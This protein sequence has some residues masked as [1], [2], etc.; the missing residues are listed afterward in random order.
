VCTRAPRSTVGG[1]GAVVA[2]SGRAGFCVESPSKF[3][4]LNPAGCTGAASNC[5]AVTLA[6]GTLAPNDVGTDR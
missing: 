6:A 3:A 5:A 4:A 2:Y 1:A